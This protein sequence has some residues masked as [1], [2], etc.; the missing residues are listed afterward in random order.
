[1][2]IQD[3]NQLLAERASLERMI[4]NLPESSVIDRLSLEARKAAVEEALAAAPVPAHEPARARLRFRGR[5]VIGSH[6]IFAEFGAKAVN[7]FTD[8]VAAIGASQGTALGTRGAIPNREQFQLLITGTAL[9]SFGFELEESLK[10]ECLFP[11]FSQVDHAIEQTRRIMEASLG[12]DDELTEAIVDAD[13]RAIEALRGFLQTLVENEAVCDLE[14]KD[15]VF[16][17]RDLS[18]VRRSVARLQQDNIHEEDRS[19]VGRFLGVLPHRRS[20]EF[21]IAEPREIIVGK[22]G[23]NIE[24]AGNINHVLG[25]DITI[26]VHTKRAGTGRPT[27][28]LLSYERPEQV[29]KS[30]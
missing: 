21:Q 25:E 3:R 23:P 30:S 4:A 29:A 18:Q 5:P 20:F 10:N 13:P 15:D 22:V 27:Y 19:L 1:M 14:L 7:T 2:N 8:A 28:T 16:R 17:F 12:S 9:G 24:D 11:G 26:Q 6:G